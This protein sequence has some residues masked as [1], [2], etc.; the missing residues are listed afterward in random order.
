MPAAFDASASSA[1]RF[2]WKSVTYRSACHQSD[3]S[4]AG[5][6]IDGGAR[7]Q[8]RL[9]DG[10]FS[11]VG[12]AVSVPGSPKASRRNVSASGGGELVLFGG[13]GRDALEGSP[14]ASGA[15]FGTGRST[16]R[17]SCASRPAASMSN[18]RAT[19]R[20]LTRP[21]SATWWI[22]ATVAV[23]LAATARLCNFV[24]TSRIGPPSW[25]SHAGV[26]SDG[27]DGERRCMR[28]LSLVSVEWRC[29]GEVGVREPLVDG[30]RHNKVQKLLC[31]ASDGY[32]AAGSVLTT[33]RKDAS[34]RTK[35]PDLSVASTLVWGLNDWLMLAEMCGIDFGSGVQ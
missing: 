10:A 20:T 27:G 1:V 35:A 12:V 16:L 5:L 8:R 24:S 17:M 9:C 28:M 15:G 23:S 30:P 6:L 25:A 33:S 26:A 14:V 32:W 7:V 29:S 2:A 31:P 34:L 13:F 22:A 21:P 11:V 18:A 19:W 3:G 4:E